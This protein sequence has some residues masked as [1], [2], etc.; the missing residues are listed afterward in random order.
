MENLQ[1]FWRKR[2]LRF[3]LA[4]GMVLAVLP[5]AISSGAAHML[6]HRRI[7]RP[8]ADIVSGHRS[9][10]QPLQ[11]LQLILWDVSGTVDEYA[12]DGDARHVKEFQ[13]QEGKIN[14]DLKSLENAVK[15]RDIQAEPIQKVRKDWLATSEIAKSIL[16]A[17]VRPKEAA[18]TA[19]LVNELQ[20]NIDKLA[21]QLN[22]TYDDLRVRSD[23]AYGQVIKTLGFSDY[24][25]AGAFGVSFLF[26]ILGAQVIDRTLVASTDRLVSAAL[27]LASGDRSQRV[28][29]LIPPELVSVASAFNTMIAQIQEQEAVLSRAATIDGLTGLLNRREFDRLLAEEIQ[30]SER[31]G[32]TMSLIM[33]DIDNFKAFNDTFGHQGGDD[34]L[35]VVASTLE[36]QVRELDKVCRFGGEELAVILPASDAESARRIAERLRASVAAEE[37]NLHDSQVAKVT[38]SLGVASY[39]VCGESPESLL[40]AADF[41]LYQSKQL[42]RNCV[43]VADA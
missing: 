35:C 34:A 19:N 24:L 36:K 38:V 43:S 31:Y 42:G 37:I 22:A 2:S 7:I 27:R 20:A 11:S 28:Q 41:A 26:I 18:P 8:L 23:H 9:I 13:K 6:Y 30:R 17:G 12:V 5:L 25:V 39:P 40:R 1:D 4:T 32:S 10:L 15:Q 14:A 29:V 33:I 3:W 16:S 21:E